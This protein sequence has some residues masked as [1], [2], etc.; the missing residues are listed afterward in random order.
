[1]PILFFGE[2]FAMCGNI[3]AGINAAQIPIKAMAIINKLK[4]AA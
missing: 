4:L 2:V 3:D 1:M